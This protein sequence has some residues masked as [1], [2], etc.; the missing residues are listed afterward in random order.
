MLFRSASTNLT[1]WVAIK[2]NIADT[3]TMTFTNSTAL[4]RRFFRLL[5]L[6]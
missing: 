5:E 6:P 1:S 4:P 2:T 3:T